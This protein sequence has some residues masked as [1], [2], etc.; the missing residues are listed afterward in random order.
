MNLTAIVR[1][2]LQRRKGK[3]LMMLLGIAIS[4]AAMVTV[5]NIVQAMQNKL[6]AQLSSFGVNMV[7]TPDYGGLTFSYGGFK[8]PEILYDVQ[9]LAGED[10]DRLERSPSREKIR[11]VSPKLIVMD[12]LPGGQAVTVIG[13]EISQEFQ[14]KPWL[15]I[16]SQTA[17]LT[18]ADHEII[19]GYSLASQLL[20]REG[21]QIILAGQPFILRHVLAASG[22][23]EDNQILM[24]LAA[25]QLAYG[26]SG[27]ITVIDLMVDTAAGT[28][29]LLI[30]E[31]GEAL[32]HAQVTSL[33]QES[34]RRDMLLGNIV[35]FGAAISLLILISGL[36]IAGVTM[37]GSVRERTREIGIFRAL[38]FRKSHLVAMLLLEVI[39]VCLSGGVIGFVAGQALTV[40]AGQAVT[41][42]VLPFAWNLAALLPS[43]GLS[44][45]MGFAAGLMPA[46]KAARVDAAEA[47]RFI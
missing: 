17:P 36:L 27:E 41:G 19:A 16:Q 23:A 7:I 40:L 21:D 33:R 2:N 6:D 10:L 38:G 30:R 4:I 13:A 11:L 15:A 34:L 29:E 39:V 26:R 25:A 47:L 28:D 31:I 22:E 5:F 20:L 8:L 44:M 37:S 9:Q 24:N 45:L 12:E 18:L 3:T 43:L 32:P 35:R 1:G 14:I 46:L 42:E